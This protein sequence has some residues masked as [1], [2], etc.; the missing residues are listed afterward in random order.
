[1]KNFL[2]RPCFLLLLTQLLFP[3]GTTYAQGWMR[4]IT[5]DTIYGEV[6][7]TV[8]HPGGGVVVLY[9]AVS[10]VKMA[11]YNAD[12][13]FVW[14]QTVAAPGTAKDLA[15]G[16]D[17]LP[18]VLA[19]DGTLNK[20]V[21]YHYDWQ[22]N[23]LGSR[24]LDEYNSVGSRPQLVPFPGGGFA[25]DLIYRANPPAPPSRVALYRL[26][27]NDSPLWRA[28][29]D[30]LKPIPVMENTGVGV[31]AQGQSIVGTRIGFGTGATYYLTAFDAQGDS[32]WQ[33][34]DLTPIT[35]GALADG[36]FFYVQQHSPIPGQVGPVDIVLRKI[37]PAGDL[38]WET[39]CDP[40]T[41]FLTRRKYLARPDGSL[42]LC[43]VGS[44]PL[45][46]TIVVQVFD[47]QGNLLK[48]ISRELP[49]Y[50]TQDL[51][52]Y[53]IAPAPGGGYYVSG[54]VDAG[55]ARAFILKMDE[56]GEVYPQRIWG[57]FADDEDKNCVFDPIE[58]G[59]EGHK[60]VI[61]DLATGNTYYYTGS[62]SAG[63]YSAEVDSTQFLVSAYPVNPYWA[64]CQPDTLL[65]FSTGTDSI[66]VDFPLQKVVECPFLEVDLST[67]ILRRCYATIYHVR[68]CNTGTAPATDVY[69][70]IWH[71]P[72]QSYVSSSIPGNY[73]GGRHW[74]FPIGD[75]PFG[76]CGDFTLELYLDCDSTVLGQTHCVE[77]HIYPDSFCLQNGQWSGA[78]V[79]VNG[80]CHPDSVDLVIKNTGT[81]PNS[82]PLEYV[83]IEDNIIFLQGAFQLPAGDSMTVRVPS[84][85]STWRLEAEQ[86]PFSPGD[87]MPS[88]TVEGCGL[89]ANGAFSIGFVSQF[90]ENDGNP[91][92][93]VDCREN[94][95][96]YDPNDK[97]AFPR[98]V[99]AEHWIM[100][101]TELEYLIRFQNTGNDTAFTVVI[102]DTLAPWLDPLSVRPG[103]SSHPYTFGLSGKGNVQFTFNNILLPDSITNEPASQGFVKFFARVR[104]DVPQGTL[105]PNNAA[106][107]FDFNAPVITNTAFHTVGK[108]YLTT[109]A[110]PGPGIAPAF[111]IFPNPATD[112]AIIQLGNPVENGLAEWFDAQGR[113]LARQVFRGDRVLLR[114]GTLPPGLYL[115]RVFDGEKWLGNGKVVWR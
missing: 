112:E 114:A 113:M 88:A 53:A 77:A 17:G 23:L 72:Y 66:R 31:N 93:S 56:N 55:T 37:S 64:S 43:G 30:T 24:A 33:R 69:V 98:G 85:G 8:Q 38:I 103:A 75:V 5:P 40:N 62:D 6:E 45:G 104:P 79:E 9:T 4:F 110:G 67:G 20:M 108:N 86:E 102:R 7:E 10:Q 16:T 96:S 81:A 12:G 87:P 51:Y 26:D 94:R 41:V 44:G 25:C 68:Y 61:E 11:H 19:H 73:L 95:S 71:D 60:V 111:A 21:L 82:V 107:Y 106:I 15:I 83:I 29:I 54:Y 18:A 101:G 28:D 36:N 39:P 14:Q 27:A 100:P 105:L 99:G 52:V 90:G 84:N 65:D 76:D 32:L 50:A 35:A 13:G 89:N 59:M 48:F 47:A 42:V 92:V 115:I 34:T 22:G 80:V 1:M 3:F 49:G 97:Q 78:N 63:L 109:S 74:R 57:Y 2:L 58:N 91:Y 46:K 70:D